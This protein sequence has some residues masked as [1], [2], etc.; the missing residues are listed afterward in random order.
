MS[1]VTLSISQ[2]TV[3]GQAWNRNWFRHHQ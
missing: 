2:D 3:Y 1:F